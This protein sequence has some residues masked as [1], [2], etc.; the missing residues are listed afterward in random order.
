MNADHT[1]EDEFRTPDR[2]RAHV[3]EQIIA[4]G[5]ALVDD[6]QAPAEPS[7][8]LEDLLVDLHASSRD[9]RSFE[10][11]CHREGVQF[12]VILH[13]RIPR[14]RTIGEDMSDSTASTLRMLRSAYPGG[15]PKSSLI[16]V[17]RS[18]YEHMSDRQLA[19]TLAAASGE[20]AAVVLNVVYRAVALDWQ[21]PAVQAVVAVLRRHG[22]DDWCKEP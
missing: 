7:D 18:L 9:L 17:A 4:V 3:V 19:A 20:D 1:L 13:R 11:W 8:S 6:L 5:L 15:V 21:D 14:H 10:S 2:V 12:D 22:Y 16:P